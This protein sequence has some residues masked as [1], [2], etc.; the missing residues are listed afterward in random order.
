MTNNFTVTT[1]LK[2]IL[3]RYAQYNNIFIIKFG[4]SLKCFEV[5]SSNSYLIIAPHFNILWNHE[6]IKTVLLTTKYIPRGRLPG[7]YIIKEIV[8]KIKARQTKTRHVRFYKGPYHSLMYSFPRLLVVVRL[9]S[10]YISIIVGIVNSF[11]SWFVLSLVWNLR[12]ISNKAKA[13]NNSHETHFHLEETEWSTDSQY[14]LMVIISLIQI[15]DWTC[16][17][18]QI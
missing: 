1:L 5:H 15:A 9:Q 6:I 4:V 16:G 18:F 14:D 11:P 13:I 2:K 3:G 12:V 7:T 8:K 17:D 10:I